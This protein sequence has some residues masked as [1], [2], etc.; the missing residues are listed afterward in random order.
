VPEPLTDEKESIEDWSGC[1]IKHAGG[2]EVMRAYN[3]VI[4]RPRNDYSRDTVASTN[5]MLV[6]QN[7]AHFIDWYTGWLENTK[8]QRT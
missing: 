8:D 6:F 3:G 2:F 5:Q 7:P 4:V 1:D